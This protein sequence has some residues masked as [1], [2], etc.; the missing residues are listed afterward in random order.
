MYAKLFERAEKGEKSANELYEKIHNLSHQ[1]SSISSQNSSRNLSRN[2]SFRIFGNALRGSQIRN[3]LYNGEDSC[4]SDQKTPGNN[5]NTNLG[6][7][8][9]NDHININSNA[10]QKENEKID[11][12][13]SL[14]DKM[15]K[16]E[17]EESSSDSETPGNNQQ[18]NFNS[19][20]TNKNQK[21]NDKNNGKKS[22]IDRMK[23][24]KNQ[25]KNKKENVP[26]LDKEKDFE[27]DK[28]EDEKK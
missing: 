3:E 1:V 25:E 7:K 21:E 23:E 22:L 17:N 28:K 27:E 6:F 14:I 10:N 16:V 18:K 24:V 13:K 8:N 26:K 19:S 2:D 20:C 15:K 11:G 4:D 9:A 5:Q 12:K